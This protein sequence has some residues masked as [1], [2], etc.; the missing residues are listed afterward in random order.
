MD[1]VR[2]NGKYLLGYVW[3]YGGIDVDRQ[4]KEALDLERPPVLALDL[5][6]YR[7]QRSGVVSWPNVP[8]IDEALNLCDR[9]GQRV[10]NYTGKWFWK[11]YLKQTM[12]FAGRDLWSGEYNGVPTLDTPS[13]GG[14]NIVG[15]Q[16]A[17]VAP[18]GISLDMDVFDAAWVG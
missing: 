5:E 11:D 4:V 1:S 7:D 10:V 15:H 16:Y 13:Y 6:T 8:E 17:D 12:A 3:L 18:D 14:M 2:A 9:M